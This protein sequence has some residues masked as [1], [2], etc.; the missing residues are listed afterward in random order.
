MQPSASR[1]TLREGFF[2]F[3]LVGEKKRMDIETAT[4]SKRVTGKTPA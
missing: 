2:E 4:L 1:S 3:Q